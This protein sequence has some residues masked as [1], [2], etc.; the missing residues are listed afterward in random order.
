MFP[1]ICSKRRSCGIHRKIGTLQDAERVAAWVYQIARN[2][3]RDHHRGTLNPTVALGDAANE[4]AED[5]E[6]KSG[7]RDMTWLN[8]MIRSLPDGYRQAV[9]M[10][11]IEEHTQQDVASRLG[12]SLSGAKS[13]IQ[14]GRAMLKDVL[15]RC[16]SFELDVRGRVMGCDP[17]SDQQ[18]CRECGDGIA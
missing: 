6:P 16:C 1:T 17:K 18:M 14:R 15:K 7:C 4:R 5:R 11:E 10:A 2:V 12:L 3:V 13:R 9:Q 8:E